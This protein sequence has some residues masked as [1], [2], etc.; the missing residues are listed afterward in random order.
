MDQLVAENLYKTY[1]TKEK[2]GFLKPKK[3]RVV[4]AVRGISM[5][6]PK[7]R[8]IGLLGVNGAGKTTTIRMLCSMV[9]PTSGSIRIDGV[10]GVKNSLQ[11]KGRLNM[12]TGGERNL[13]WRL[14]ARENLAYFG[15]LYGLSGAELKRRSQTLLDMVGLTEA[16]D[17]PVERYS[18]GMKQRLQIARGLINDPAYLFLD[19][20]TLGLDVLIAKEMRQY[21]AGLAA[22][23][24]KGLLLTTH[25]ISEAE[26]LCDYIYVIDKGLI[27]AEGTKAELTRLFR[28]TKA[29]SVS[30][31]EIGPEL[32][33]KLADLAQDQAELRFSPD[34]Q[35]GLELRIVGD[36]RCWP[37]LLKAIGDAGLA[38]EHLRSNEPD[39]EQA[40]LSII[41]DSR[42]NGGPRI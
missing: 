7:G 25:Y 12:I 4:E 42:H 19:E 10:D 34:G 9:S 40:L 2:A 1:H 27:I 33:Q 23:Q 14:T 11:V 21:I 8:I 6:I 38:V 3:R 26:A 41:G 39:L 22:E 13:Y 15:R 16:A 35:G 5:T 17:L 18:K 29:L 36:S 24:H 20:P 32:R 28:S 31:P 37:S 30:L